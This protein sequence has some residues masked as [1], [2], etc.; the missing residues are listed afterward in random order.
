M[1]VEQQHV[2][3]AIGI[4]NSS[5]TVMLTITDHLEWHNE[6]LLLLQEK[7]NTYISFVENEDIY[8]TYPKAKNRKI[9][10]NLICKFEPTELGRQFLTKAASILHGAGIDFSLNVAP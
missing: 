10:I 4:E 9:C 3:D 8:E 2:I 6:H 7:L 1:S 5:G